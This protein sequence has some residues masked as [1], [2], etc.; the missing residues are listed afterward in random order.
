MLRDAVKLN[1]TALNVFLAGCRRI[2]KPVNNVS[3]SLELFKQLL[4]YV[5]PV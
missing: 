4:T 2:L 1:K 3:D 5:K